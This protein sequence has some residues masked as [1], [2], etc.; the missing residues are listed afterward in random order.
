M[1]S[2][3]AW[4]AATIGA[5]AGG[6][7]SGSDCA[8]DADLKD[9]NRVE[10][11]RRDIMNE[12]YASELNQTE[13]EMDTEQSDDIEKD[14]KPTTRA[15]KKDPAQK[16]KDKLWEQIVSKAAQELDVSS[17]ESDSEDAD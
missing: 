5:A 6:A 7:P 15:I 17:S 16:K 12:F 3:A 10:R 2:G 1:P 4:N 8:G 9:L 13:M 14:N 11:G